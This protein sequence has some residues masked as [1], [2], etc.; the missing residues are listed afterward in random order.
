[1]GMSCNL[2]RKEIMESNGEITFNNQDALF[3]EEDP[4]RQFIK[5]FEI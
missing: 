4:Y 1:M 2:C 3:K 5:K